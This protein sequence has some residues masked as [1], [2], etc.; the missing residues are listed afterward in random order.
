MR[1]YAFVVITITWTPACGAVFLSLLPLYLLVFLLSI[2]LLS[3]LPVLFH[4]HV[5]S[6]AFVYPTMLACSYFERFIGGI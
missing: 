6:W 5:L 1:V 3:C 2:H 4:V